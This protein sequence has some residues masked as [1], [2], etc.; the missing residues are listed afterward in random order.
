VFA[1]GVTLVGTGCNRNQG[2]NPAAYGN[3]AP[4][5]EN[6]YP[7]P[8]QNAYSVGEAEPYELPAPGGVQ[9]ATAPAPPPSMPKYRQPPC[10]G[11]NYI[12][13]PGYWGY[14]DVGYY[15]VPGAWIM[16]PYVG[17]LWT[18]PWWEFYGA[19][20]RWHHGYWGRYIG[21]YGA[22]DYGYG[23]T[24]LGF[25]GGYW[26]NGRFYYNRA[27]ANVDPRVTPY[28]YRY[29]ITNY[30]PF[31]RVSYNGGPGGVTRQA[32]AREL[33]VRSG[34]RMAP[35][36]E[37]MQNARAA[38]M[39]PRQFASGNHGHPAMTTQTGPAA[40][41]NRAAAGTPHA[42]ERHQGTPNLSGRAAM[43]PGARFGGASRMERVPAQHMPVEHRAA[44]GGFHR[45]IAPHGH[46][47]VRGH[48]GGHMTRVYRPPAQAGFHGGGHAFGGGGHFAGG[49]H[50]FGNG[51]GHGGGHMAGGAPAF[52]HGGHGFGGGGGGHGGGGGG[53]HGGGGGGHGGGGGGHGGGHK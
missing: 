8:N 44:A 22:I 9:L 19:G 15:W 23:Y 26:N 34:M 39:D 20:Y 45:E 50:A 25:D 21:F 36:A 47:A 37:Q 30:T 29:S 2:P 4:A 14:G 38:A 3:L 41:P 10:P 51:G 16:A 6:A 32:T 11:P 7:P 13:T 12:W 18:P 31:N 52:G 43:G 53:G 46:L 1:S 49:P 28:V 5:G 35:V 24:G 27:V 40:M 33:A 17:A 42:V 48:A